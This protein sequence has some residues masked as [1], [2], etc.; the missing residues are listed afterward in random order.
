MSD[1]TD[2]IN[3]YLHHYKWEREVPS[4]IMEEIVSMN[5]LGEGCWFADWLNHR[6]YTWILSVCLIEEIPPPYYK[7]F[8][9]ILE[10]AISMQ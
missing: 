10:E 2:E 4:F 5:E 7:D 1:L 8:E 9:D 3:M 6:L